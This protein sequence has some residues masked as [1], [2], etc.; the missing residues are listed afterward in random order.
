MADLTEPKTGTNTPA[1]G[2]QWPLSS[3]FALIGFIFV[4]SVMTITGVSFTDDPTDPGD[5]AP[6][7]VAAAGDGLA[8]SEPERTPLGRVNAWV[9][10]RVPGKELAFEFERTT[11]RIIDDNYEG[12]VAANERVHLGQDGWLFITDATDVMCVTPEREAQW[13]EEIQAV[14]DLLA[15]AGKETIIAIAP[16]RALM[17]PELVGE[18]DNDCQVANSQV[19]ERLAAL[20]QVL[21]LSTAV[22]G[23]E[24]ALQLDTHWSPAGA[25]AGMKLVVN[26]IEPGLWGDVELA[27]DVVDRPG[28]LD[29][30]VGYANTETVNLVSVEQ[31]VPTDLNAIGTS[32]GGRP[33]V[34]ARTPGA[35][36]RNVL[37]IHDSFGGYFAAADPTQYQTGSGV[38]YVRPWFESVDNVRLAGDN[39]QSITDQPVV[40]ALA[41]S[42]VVV[43][44]FVQRRLDF[45]FAPG[46]L[47]EPLA[48]ALQAASSEN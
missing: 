12:A 1:P 21:D 26:E 30:L 46:L 5:E 6:F 38:H 32:I 16:D 20:P 10:D 36:D 47:S 2:R 41:N 11:T 7:D 14:T 17:V 48:Q 42:E 45:R 40:E 33:L 22:G 18:I 44:L 29:G 37:L 43:F 4:P 28:D 34:Q 8:F 24:H 9:E 23:E 27:S 3:L 15:D 19:I 25:A 13:V 31:E 35:L 39:A